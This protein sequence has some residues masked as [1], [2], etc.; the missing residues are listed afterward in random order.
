MAEHCFALSFVLSIV[1]LSAECSCAECRYAECRYAECRVDFL[2]LFFRSTDKRNR[3]Q[4]IHGLQLPGA[5][6][7]KLFTPYGA[8]S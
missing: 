2:V 3:G 8:L 6:T 5:C 7:A 1:M 4:A